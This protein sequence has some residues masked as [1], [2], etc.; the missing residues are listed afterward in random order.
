MSSATRGSSKIFAIEP[1]DHEGLSKAV[2][3]AR[4]DYEVKW[5]WKYGQPAFDLVSLI[6]EVE[7]K[8]LGNVVSGFMKQNGRETQVTAEVFPYGIVVPDRYRLELNIRSHP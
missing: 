3:L 5:W 2:G 7:G 8:Q 4:S 6:I 1:H